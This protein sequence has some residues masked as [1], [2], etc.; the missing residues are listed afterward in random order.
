MK[1]IKEVYKYREL[2]GELVKRDIKIKYRRSILGILWSVLNPLLFMVVITIVFSTIFK[3]NI[4]N[5]PIYF[6]CGQ[7]IFAFFSEATSVAQT[8]II[9]NSAL[10][11]KVYIPKYIFPFSKVCAALVNVGFSLIAIVIM[12]ILL[13][14][15]PPV[16]TILF[17]IPVFYAFLYATG[18][19]LLIS[20]L[21]VFF[22]DTVHLYSIVITILSYFSALFYPV[23]IIPTEY[24]GLIYFNPIYIFIKYFRELILNGRIPSLEINIL[25]IAHCVL[26]LIVGYY[27]FKKSE[28]KFILYI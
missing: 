27:T 8:S 21:A 11:K 2:L 15:V 16:T 10:I 13:K 24:Q 18:V 28:N 14:Y 6:L 19:S 4:E 5:F 9:G 7:I 3:S 12:M 20:S 25:C 26:I 17:V 1:P 23:E 22:R